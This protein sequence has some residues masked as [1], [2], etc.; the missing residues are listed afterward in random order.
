MASENKDIN[1]L[2]G[3]LLAAGVREY[4]WKEDVL[5]EILKYKKLKIVKEFIS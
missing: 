5:R 1:M 4:E 3:L 2:M